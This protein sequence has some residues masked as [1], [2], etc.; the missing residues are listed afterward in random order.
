MNSVYDVVLKG[1]ASAFTQDPPQSL[2]PSTLLLRRLLATE[3]LDVMTL[4]FGCTDYVHSS[5]GLVLRF[6]GVRV[7]FACDALQHNPG[8]IADALVND[9][10]H[11]RYLFIM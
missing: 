3:V 5:D 1:T 7:E 6:L 10:S 2:H 4:E 8:H 11:L 9:L